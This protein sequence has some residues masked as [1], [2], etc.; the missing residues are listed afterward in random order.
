MAT[1][2]EDLRTGAYRPQPVRRMMIA[3][4]K[5]GLRPLGIPTATDK[6]VQSVAARILEEVYEAVFSDHSLGFRKGRS[7]HY[8]LT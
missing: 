3:K 2:R 1:I 8:A 6:L 5:G 7:C 4:S